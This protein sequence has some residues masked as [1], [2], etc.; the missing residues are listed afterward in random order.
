MVRPKVNPSPF[1]FSNVSLVPP[2]PQFRLGEFTPKS[3]KAFCWTQS[4]PI[5]SECGT[6]YE[7]PE[8]AN[9]FCSSGCQG[10]WKQRMSTKRILVPVKFRNQ[11]WVGR[12]DGLPPPEVAAI[13]ELW[14][15]SMD[16][17]QFIVK[18]GARM[19]SY[20]TNEWPLR[21]DRRGLPCQLAAG[22]Q[23]DHPGTGRCRYHGGR[24]KQS[25]TKA[26][27]ERMAEQAKVDEMIYGAPAEQ[28][29]P[30]EAVMQEL[31][32]TAGHVQWLFDQLQKEEAELV[33]A[34]ES[35]SKVL[36]QFTKLGQTPSVYIDLYFRERQH[37]L[38]VAKTA[39]G[40]GIAE[41]QIRLA[42]EQ[43]Q[44][45][46][47]VLRGFIADM[48][49]TPEQMVRAPGLIRKH[50]EQ[51]QLTVAPQPRAPEVVLRDGMLADTPREDDV[52]DVDPLEDDDPED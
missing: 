8:K 1:L 6:A 43:G 3:W 42:E 29:D 17:G 22:W 26:M 25:N 27:R 49:L 34:G 35:R 28:I 32:R 31:A 47:Q 36:K 33:E 10:R 40:M 41:R 4:P 2:A 46:A 24:T 48:Q 38:T 11:Q 52:I 45:L 30:G 23:T 14:N 19:Y 50:L 15:S 16:T 9:Y 44:L 12:E 13:R 51:I 18:C 5:C 20:P 7:R 37:L 39:S 21:P